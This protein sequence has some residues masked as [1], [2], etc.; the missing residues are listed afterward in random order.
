MCAR[1]KW[2][3]LPRAEV[4]FFFGEIPMLRIALR[5]R[6]HSPLCHSECSEAKSKCE[7]PPKAESKGANSAQDDGEKRLPRAEALAMTRN[8]FCAE[9][10]PY[11]LPLHY[12][13]LP[14]KAPLMRCF[15]GF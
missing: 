15:L 13:L 4:G 5:V 10:T 2:N 14:E 3:R 12:Y 1:K 11:L 9:G 8:Q 6:L 7:A